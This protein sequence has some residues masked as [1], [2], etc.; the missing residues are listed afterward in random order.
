M[1][2]EKREELT[3]EDEKSIPYLTWGGCLDFD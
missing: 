2:N 3:V 1:S